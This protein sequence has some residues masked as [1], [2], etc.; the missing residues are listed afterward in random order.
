MAARTFLIDT[1][2]ASDDAVALI[3]ALRAGVAGIDVRVAAITT[4][5]GNVPVAQATRNALYVAE[6]CESDVPVFTGA[7]QPLCREYMHAEWFHGRDGLGDH[8]Y[9]TPRR[10][11]DPTHAATHGVDAILACVHENPGLTIVTLGPLTNVALA[12][13]QDPAI[14]AK[15]GRCVIMG[16]NPCCEGNVTPAAEYNIWVDPEAARIVLRSGM[17]IDLAGWHLCRAEAAR[18]PADIDRVLALDT[19]LARFAIE[20]NSTAMAAY[21]A[22]TGESGIS[23]PDP[24]AMAIALDPSLCTST[25][26]HF[27]DVEAASELT[28]GMTVVDRLNVAGD[29]RN[30]HVWQ[31][32]MAKNKKIRV[33]WSIDIPR[34]KDALI[35]S[36]S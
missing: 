26:E 24:I 2:T 16:G 31:P 22:Q 4:V 7:V 23:L 14:S 18:N 12:L 17:P 1:D 9:P 6:L 28:R 32:L 20:C 8:A 13:A 25:S 10:S 27:V 5:A 34:W 35:R 33:C 11:A 30:R 3:M 36:L 21:R 29:D 19:P 15:V